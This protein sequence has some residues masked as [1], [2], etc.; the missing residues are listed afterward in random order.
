MYVCKCLIFSNIYEEAG[1]VKYISERVISKKTLR[2]NF[3]NIFETW[4]F[5]N[6][7]LVKIVHICMEWVKWIINPFY[8]DQHQ[9]ACEYQQRLNAFVIACVYISRSR[10]VGGLNKKKSVKSALWHPSR[11]LI[12][13]DS[14]L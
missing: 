14:W 2:T 4:S 5:R 7:C 12:L 1:E 3:V 6:K 9:S 10:F 11:H 13:S 8:S